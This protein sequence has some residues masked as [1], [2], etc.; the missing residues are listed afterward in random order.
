MDQDLGAR[1]PQTE[2][3]VGQAERP[4]ER[5]K[6]SYSS[7]EGSPV[8]RGNSNPNSLNSEEINGLLGFSDNIKWVEYS[9][10]FIILNQ[11]KNQNPNVRI[12]QSAYVFFDQNL[13]REKIIGYFQTREGNF[14]SYRMHCFHLR[15]VR[16]YEEA[17]IN[18]RSIVK[19]A[20]P[21]PE[22]YLRGYN[23]NTYINLSLRDRSSG[24]SQGR[25]LYCRDTQGNYVK[26][27]LN[28]SQHRII[29]VKRQRDA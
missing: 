18:S 21:L 14:A 29:M 9:P 13:N 22:L 16:V 19:D 15:R 27:L 26:L 3:L 28:Y 24:Y 5:E 4:S 7:D 20:C 25:E 17:N 23:R 10:T 12:E 1:T 11:F 2:N 8:E 6:S